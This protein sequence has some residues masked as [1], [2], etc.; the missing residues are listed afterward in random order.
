[1]RVLPHAL[2]AIAVLCAAPALVAEL[3][4]SPTAPKLEAE[5]DAREVRGRIQISNTYDSPLAI[6][7]VRASCGC[8]SVQLPSLPDRPLIL[9]PNEAVEVALTVDLTHKAGAFAKSLFFETD[10][11]LVEIRIEVSRKPGP[12]DAHDEIRARNMQLAQAD[13]QAVFKGDC[14]RCHSP[15]P[16]VT[17]G[18]LLYGQACGICHESPNRAASVPLLRTV[19]TQERGYWEPWIRDG[20][21]GTMMPAFAKASGGP[22]SDEQI[23]AL[24][25]FLTGRERAAA[26]LVNPSSRHDP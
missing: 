6:T 3:V 4:W 25:R 13:R 14:A 24:L 2:F 8:T 20:K 26:G 11:G 18:R 17:E 15:A 22:L 16:T 5:A 1:M 12:T 9:A 10:R 7:A 21:Q 19:L 23:E